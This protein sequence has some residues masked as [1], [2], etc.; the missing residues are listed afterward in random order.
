MR[1]SRGL[2]LISI[3]FMLQNLMAQQYLVLEKRGTPR[4]FKYSTGDLISLY[5]GGLFISGQITGMNDSVVTLD[6]D[7]TVKLKNITVIERR[8]KF[9]KAL[10]ELFFIRGGIAY[11]LIEGTNRTINH[12]YPVITD[13]TIKVS[14]TAIAFGILIRPL[15]KRKFRLDKKWQLKVLDFDGFN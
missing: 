8:R 14:G 6:H 5:A 9:L 13:N 3:I 10:S 15:I 1:K 7:L 4:N 12:E 2:L 11:F